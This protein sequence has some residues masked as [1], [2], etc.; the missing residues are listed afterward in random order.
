MAFVEV[1]VR[2]LIGAYLF[3]LL[4]YAGLALVFQKQ[5]SSVVVHRGVC[6]AA[7]LWTVFFVSEIKVIRWVA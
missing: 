7:F 1:P 2:V 6:V 3:P 4:I 5:C